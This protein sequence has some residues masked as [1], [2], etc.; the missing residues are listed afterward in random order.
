MDKRKKACII[1]VWRRQNF[2][3]VLIAKP[4]II[5]HGMAPRQAKSQHLFAGVALVQQTWSI[6]K[7]CKAENKLA[8]PG[9]SLL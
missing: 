6:V 7:I 3:M 4:W 1:K 9:E 5:P 8:K 2:A